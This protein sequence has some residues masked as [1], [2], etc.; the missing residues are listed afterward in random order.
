MHALVPR[1]P[2]AT[3]PINWWALITVTFDPTEHFNLTS[4]QY[5]MQDSSLGYLL[6]GVAHCTL[7]LIS[8]AGQ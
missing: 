8:Y 6:Y 2:N 7:D 3:S 5:Y 1:I 4:Q